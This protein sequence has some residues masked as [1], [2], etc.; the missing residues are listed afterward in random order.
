MAVGSLAASDVLKGFAHTG[1][2]T[3]SSRDARRGSCCSPSPLFS[4][5]SGGPLSDAVW[6]GVK[7]VLVLRDTLCCFLSQ[8]SSISY[9]VTKCRARGPSACILP[10]R[11]G[12][13]LWEHRTP[14]TSSQGT[15][16]ILCPGFLVSAFPTSG[17]LLAT[18]ACQLQCQWAQA[19]N[20]NEYGSRK[21]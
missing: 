17:H 12:P 15:S 18:V 7:D 3:P 16:G 1:F 6:G 21:W 13:S 9:L 2:R 10:P 4:R 8:E 11:P 5:V 14:G 20:V 19:G